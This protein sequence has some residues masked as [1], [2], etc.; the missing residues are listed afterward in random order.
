MNL[1][2][3][4]AVIAMSA[5]PQ[6]T[7]AAPVGPQPKAP[8]EKQITRGPGG[9]ILTNTGVWS[10]DSQWIVYDIRSDAAGDRFD[11]SR[12]EMVHAETG[13]VKVLYRAQP[14]AHCG[15]VTFS[16][17]APRVAFIVGPENPTSD[18]EYG[19]NHR[20]GRIVDLT[21][22]GRG[23]NLDARDL[24]PPFTPGAL[25]GGSH[26][27]VWDARGEWIAFTYHDALV[28]SDLPDIGGGAPL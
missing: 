22:P 6:T 13:E 25:R 20:Q 3:A 14:G 1:L 17:V 21:R 19:V 5:I 4:S 24:T 26:V 12:I 7:G 8:V 16:P 18:W 2:W 27:H 10:P 28:E 15:V 9:H 11:G 23:W